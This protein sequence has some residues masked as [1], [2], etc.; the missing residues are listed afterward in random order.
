[1]GRGTFLLAV[2]LAVVACN[3]DR[4]R[5]PLDYLSVC[6]PGRSTSECWWAL[7]KAPQKTFPAGRLEGIEFRTELIPP[8][9]GRFIPG[10]KSKEG[11]FFY[12]MR[13]NVGREDVMKILQAEL[14][15]P[16]KSGIAPVHTFTVMEG[17]YW[18]TEEGFWVCGEKAVAWYSN[19]IRAT[20][21]A[22]IPVEPSADLNRYVGSVPTTAALWS[23]LGRVLIGSDTTPRS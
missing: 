7:E 10:V 11:V 6:T 17:D 8:P 20:D 12:A 13:F 19:T 16:L 23:K 4:A 18:Q 22:G 3:K 15:E 14:G 1:M 2:A 5:G 21:E 9:G